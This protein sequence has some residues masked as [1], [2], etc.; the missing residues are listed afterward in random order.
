MEEIIIRLEVPSELEP[1][2]KLALTKLIKQM[3]RDV[4]FSILDDIMS[5]SKL[6][7]EQ[8]KELSDETNDSLAKRYKTFSS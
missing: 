5:G 1:R 6:T 7:E 4:K 3:V 8:L 2:L